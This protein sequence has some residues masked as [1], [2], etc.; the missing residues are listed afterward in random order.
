[1]ETNVTNKDIITYQSK[2]GEI[3]FDVNILGE[4]VWLTQKQMTKLFKKDIRTINEHILNIFKEGELE[5]ISTIRKFQIIQKEGSKNVLI[6][7][8]FKC[9]QQKY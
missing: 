5:R 2:D 3:S 6:G 7:N 9:L 8:S 1:M 4:T